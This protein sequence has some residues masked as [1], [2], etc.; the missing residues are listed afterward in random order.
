MYTIFI[1]VNTFLKI[2]KSSK[3]LSTAESEI[4]L[5]EKAIP[6]QTTSSE[7]VIPAQEMSFQSYR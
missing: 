7:N 1:S 3:E 2:M 5:D 6:T 4:K